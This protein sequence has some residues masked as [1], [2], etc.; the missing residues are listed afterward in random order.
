M[1]NQDLVDLS[2]QIWNY[3]IAKQII[4]TAEHLTGTLNE[5]ADFESGNVKDKGLKRMM[6][7]R[8]IFQKLCFNLGKADIDLLHLQSNSKNIDHCTK[9]QD[10]H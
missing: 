4:I 9:N 7:N 6:L 10:F 3:L 8:E 1:N 5:E 2:K